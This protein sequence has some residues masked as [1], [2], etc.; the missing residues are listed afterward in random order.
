MKK[1]YNEIRFRKLV[2]EF[3]QA[4]HEF[5][6]IYNDDKTDCW[7]SGENLKEAKARLIN[8]MERK[9]RDIETLMRNRD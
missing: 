3:Q 6:I 2:N 1:S 4:V 9:M 8:F 5:A 7:D